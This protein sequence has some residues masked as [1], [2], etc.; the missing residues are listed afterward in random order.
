MNVRLFTPNTLIAFPN[1]KWYLSPVIVGHLR[2]NAKCPSGRLSPWGRVK[3]RRTTTWVETRGWELSTLR[4]ARGSEASRG[5]TGSRSYLDVSNWYIAVE[6]KGRLTAT[7]SRSKA[8]GARKLR[9]R[10]GNT[11]T[12][13]NSRTL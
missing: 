8:R 10:R 4:E 7:S 3:T 5:E 1:A 9:E 13:S 11:A 2:R 12:N 6:D